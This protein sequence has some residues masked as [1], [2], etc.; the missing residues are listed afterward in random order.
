M[1]KIGLIAIALV[2]ALG[3]MGVGYAMWYDT[4][5][6]T[7]TVKTGS[8]NLA[9]TGVSSTYVYK[10]LDSD[11]MVTSATPITQGNYLLVASAVANDTSV[12]EAESISMVW[13]NIFPDVP[14][15]CDFNLT[16]MG[17]IPVK[18]HIV[19]A[20][21]QN[22]TGYNVDDY[23]SYK[24]TV[25]NVAFTGNPEGLQLEPGDIVHVEITL[26]IPEIQ[27]LMNQS[28]AGTI[29]IFAEQWNE[30]GLP[31]PTPLVP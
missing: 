28:A 5:A 22:F 29:T 16:N 9:I 24:V 23:L 25:N 17:T 27:G 13:N 8:V 30:F 26:K 11:L 6:I 15:T 14:F 31:L 7:G 21:T 12:G 1:K 19:A 3:T 2:L 4:V 18:L 10:N 20:Y